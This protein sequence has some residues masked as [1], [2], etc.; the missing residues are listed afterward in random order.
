MGRLKIAFTTLSKRT[1]VVFKKLSMRLT[2]PS[3]FLSRV[4]LVA[5]VRK[6]TIVPN[7]PSVAAM[8]SAD[9]DQCA[10]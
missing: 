6:I 10:C 5:N 1:T 8:V 9:S 2:S 7:H 3:K 4:P